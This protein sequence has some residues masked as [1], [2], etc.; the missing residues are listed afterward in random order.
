MIETFN[1]KFQNFFKQNFHQ[2]LLAF[3]I[4]RLFVYV[5]SKKCRTQILSRSIGPGRAFKN[6]RN[7]FK[8][9]KSRPLAKMLD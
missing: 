9:V 2:G 3:R 8:I 6:D 7:Y 1:M 5:K 4:G